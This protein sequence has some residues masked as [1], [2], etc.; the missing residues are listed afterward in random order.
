MGIDFFRKAR[1]IT[2]HACGIFIL[3]IGICHV[4]WAITLNS[5]YSTSVPAENK[6]TVARSELLQQAFRQV[7]R[8]VAGTEKLLQNEQVIVAEDKADNYVSQFS[9]IDDPEYGLQLQ[10]DFNNN[11]I[12]EL[13]R[14]TGQ[15]FLG[16]HRPLTLAWIVIDDL[17]GQSIVGGGV[18]TDVQKIVENLTH[19]QG[20]P[21]IIPMNDLTDQSIIDAK[22]ISSMSVQPLKDSA[23]RYQADVILSAKIT[24]FAGEWKG[25]YTLFC[26]DQTISGELVGKELS[27]QIASLIQGLSDGLVEQYSVV[28][29]DDSNNNIVLRVDNISS[30][31]KYAKISRYLQNLPVVLGMQVLKVE[32]DKIEFGLQLLSDKESLI[33]T[34]EIDKLLTSN[35]DEEFALDVNT[36]RYKAT[37]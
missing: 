22:D 36:L 29:K 30:L 28:G 2:M 27:E 6:N 4:S 18:K 37:L 5:L 3:F 19:K 1:K 11:M 8:Q 23:T 35:T 9:Y 20:L 14:S 16:S 21:V 24:Q 25:K 12:K 31:E 10:V 17:D 33:R 7:I 26:A 13:L 34:L 32:P 15:P